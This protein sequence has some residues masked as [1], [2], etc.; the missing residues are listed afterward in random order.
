[1]P[2]SSPSNSIGCLSCCSL[3]NT[4]LHGAA[5]SENAGAAMFGASKCNL[6][7]FLRGGSYL[8]AEERD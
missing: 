3:D 5:V 6:L 1:M 7:V 4:H 8:C 2:W